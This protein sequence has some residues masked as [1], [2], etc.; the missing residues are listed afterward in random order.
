MARA[1]VSASLTPDS[2]LGSFSKT[3]QICSLMH[4]A[5]LGELPSVKLVDILQGEAEEE[6]LALTHISS[7][8][9]TSGS[10]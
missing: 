4:S 1:V 3:Y 9:E 2:E 10:C 5:P 6:F 8:T 7:G